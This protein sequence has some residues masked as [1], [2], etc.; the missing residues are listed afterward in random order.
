MGRCKWETRYRV[1]FGRINGL[2]HAH[3]FPF[4]VACRGGFLNGRGLE[5]YKVNLDNIRVREAGE[6]GREGI[7]SSVLLYSTLLDCPIRRA[8]RKEVL[9]VPR[10]RLKRL[11]K[12]GGRIP[13]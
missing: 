13:S 4:E 11:R 3:D 6:K 2:S 10:G 9:A 12:Q 7:L 8:L 5:R 1:G